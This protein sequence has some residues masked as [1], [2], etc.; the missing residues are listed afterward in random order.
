[1]KYSGRLGSPVPASYND[2]LFA[3]P[4]LHTFFGRGVQGPFLCSSPFTAWLPHA[5]AAR[6]ICV[7]IRDQTSGHSS[8][9]ILFLS[10]YA[11]SCRLGPFG[12][13]IKLDK[14]SRDISDT[15]LRFA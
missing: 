9:A 7:R 1:M 12:V 6:S 10:K 11:G 2:G 15:I 4:E 3:L 13:I 5:L 8:Y 14:P